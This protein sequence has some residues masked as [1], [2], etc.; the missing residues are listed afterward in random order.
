MS[1]ELFL[2]GWGIFRIGRAGT[3]PL[4]DTNSIKQTTCKKDSK[5]HFN[6]LSISYLYLCT[7]VIFCIFVLKIKTI[8]YMKIKKSDMNII[9]I[10]NNAEA[11]S[12]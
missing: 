3:S 7:S 5:K 8:Q 9:H 10:I 6:V 1:G 2:W 12:L 4:L 11:I